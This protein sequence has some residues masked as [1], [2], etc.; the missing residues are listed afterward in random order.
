MSSQ[1]G[2]PVLVQGYIF[3]IDG[4]LGGGELR[5]LEV[6]NGQI[7]WRQ[8]IG[9]GTLIAAS[10]YLVALSERGEL[11]VVEA[12]P[13]NYREV[14]RAQVLGGRCWVAPAVADGKIYCKNN[15]GTLVCL[16]GH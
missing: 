3:G 15:Q 14:A 16:D 1:L 5:C 10:G 11:I 13:T 9:G 2:S 4:N 7:K 12:S 6:G 8:N